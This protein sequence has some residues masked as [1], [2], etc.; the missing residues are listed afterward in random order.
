M[1]TKRQNEILSQVDDAGQSYLEQNFINKS[2]ASLEIAKKESSKILEQAQ[3]LSDE[4]RFY[5]EIIDKDCERE[6]EVWKEIALYFS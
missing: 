1:T 4:Q 2:L 3:Q 6:I 5:V